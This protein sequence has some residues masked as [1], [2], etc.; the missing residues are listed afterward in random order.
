MI[1][2]R[3]R[4]S[5]RSEGRWIAGVAGGL[6]DRLGVPDLYVRAAFI[7]LAT[8]SGV[9]VAVYL[10]IWW[11]T[12]E[13]QTVPTKKEL[14]SSQRLGLA[15][16]FV[17]FVWLLLGSGAGADIATTIVAATLFFGLAV[18][19]DRSESGGLARVILPGSTGE[20]SIFRLIAGMA[21]VMGGL[22]LIA[23]SVPAFSSIGGTALVV[24]ITVVGLFVAFGPWCIK[25]RDDLGLERTARARQE[26]RAE[27]A[28]HLHDSVLQTLALIQRTDDPKRMASLARTQE[29]EL[30]GWLFGKAPIEGLE[31]LSTALE[32]AVARIETERSIAI[33]LVAV[34]DARF[35]DRSAALVAAASE[36]LVNAANHSGVDR[37]SVYLELTDG[38][39]EVWITDQGKG[40]DRSEVPADRKGLSESIE[41]RMARQGGSGIIE[42]SPGVGTEVHL[43]LPGVEVVRK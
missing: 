22:G 19:M 9:G 11:L 14:N 25:M 21:L 33:D 29:R 2:D 3:L 10:A 31:L 34:G 27:M 28:A 41:R 15:L 4:L 32:A 23:S 13:H 5:R 43:I 12:L 35:D 1:V 17:S 39:A 24:A 38:T 18:L 36:A 30:R 40:F 37:V 7:T 16:A 26:E 42:S 8:V 20:I 6:A